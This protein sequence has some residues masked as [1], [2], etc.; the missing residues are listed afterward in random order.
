MS[1]SDPVHSFMC[2]TFTNSDT[3]DMSDFIISLSNFYTSTNDAGDT[4]TV[5]GEY[6]PA[7]IRV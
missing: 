2:N 6:F 4:V 7:V 1:T 5:T 3:Y